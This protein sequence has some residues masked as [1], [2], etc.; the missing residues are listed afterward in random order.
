[1]ANPAAANPLFPG[2]P[3]VIYRMYTNP[4]RMAKSL[5][6]LIKWI[7]RQLA[8]RTALE[9]EGQVQVE[10]IVVEDREYRQMLVKSPTNWNDPRVREVL[11]VFSFRDLYLLGYLLNGVWQLYNDAHLVGSG[12]D[13]PANA[14]YWRELPF[15]GNYIGA[16]WGRKLG[17]EPM[18]FSLLILCDPA[19]NSRAIQLALYQYI[20]GI[21]E[22]TRFPQ[23]ELNLENILRRYGSD[24]V[25]VEFSEKFTDWSSIS[26]RIRRGPA[27]FVAGKGFE[28]YRK[29]LK[30]V[31][32]LLSRPPKAEL[33]DTSESESD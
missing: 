29:M 31:V 13:N 24:V 19:A 23:W 4:R 22:A 26:K 32:V 28:T 27:R 21:A 9:H 17:L 18:I 33:V 5:V 6:K 8:A 7:K 25:A 2:S 15:G 10:T 20:A 30:T 3:S 16:M 1:M 12:V 11:L 14:A